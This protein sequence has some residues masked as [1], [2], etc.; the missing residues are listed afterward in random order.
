[1]SVFASCLH[2]RIQHAVASRERI[3]YRKIKEEKKEGRKEGKGKRQR[4]INKTHDGNLITQCQAVNLRS[5][6]ICQ[7]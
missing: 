6:L 7:F 4:P 2:A 1:M 3:A 5:A